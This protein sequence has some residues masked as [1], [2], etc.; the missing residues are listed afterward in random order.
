MR[1]LTILVAGSILI[2]VPRAQEAPAAGGRARALDQGSRSLRA[3]RRRHY[4]RA[5]KSDR[6]K[7]DGFIN[8]IATVET[9]KQSPDEQLAFWL[10]AYDALVLRTVIDHYPIQGK[11]GTYPAR[12]IRQIPGAFERLTYHVA[13][14]TVTLD[15]IEQTI[16]ADFHDP[17]VYFAI[18]R[19]AVGSGRLRSE[20]FAGERVQQ[21]LAEAASESARGR[22][23]LRTDRPREWQG[24]RQSNL[25]VAGKGLC[26]GV[27]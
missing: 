13:G 9:D 1:L 12:S 21:Q 19:G 15:Q 18:G 27:R 26:R 17:R 8:S 23:P 4:Y 25:L 5:M 22:N 11:A 14:R 7:L 10:N 6:G 20:A 2:S 3:R 24:R 16:L